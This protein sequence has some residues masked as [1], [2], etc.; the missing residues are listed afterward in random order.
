[1]PLDEIRQRHV[2]A[3][4]DPVWRV[5]HETAKRT[6]GR[7]REIFELARVLEHVTVN[8]ADFELRVAFGRV[9]KETRHQPALPW[10]RV[11]E[12]WAWLLTHDVPEDV[13]QPF[14]VIIRIWRSN[15]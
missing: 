14:Y 8:S 5:K 4:F 3:C 12:L 10:E 11:P 7:V 2:I 15:W 6:L 13:R 9:A 1:M